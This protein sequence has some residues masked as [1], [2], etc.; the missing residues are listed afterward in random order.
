VIRRG[1]FFSILSPGRLT[2]RESNPV[3]G[4]A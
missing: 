3:N 1:R 2:A 4:E